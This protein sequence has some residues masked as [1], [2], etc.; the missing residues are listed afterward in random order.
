M[1]GAKVRIGLIGGG[2]MGRGHLNTFKKIEEGEIV[3]VADPSPQSRERVVKDFNLPVFAS[4]AEL[5]EATGP[6]GCVIA[7][8]HPVHLANALDCFK[9]GVHVFTE[10]PMTSKISEADAMIAAARKAKLMLAVMFQMRGN[11]ATRRAKEILDAGTLGEIRRVNMIHVGLRTNAYYR[12]CPWRGR[13]QSEGGGVLVNQSPH[14]LDRVVYLTGMPA[15]VLARTMTFGHPIETEDQAEA[16]LLYPNGATGYLFMSTAEA[17]AMNRLEIS[18]DRG[19][20]VIDDDNNKLLLGKLPGSCRE[21]LATN[22]EE[23]GSLKG[24]WSEVDLTP[25]PGEETGH[26]VCLRD[27]CRAIRDNRA[28]MVTGEDGKRSL[29]LANA[30]TY[31]SFAGAEVKFPLGRKAYDELYAFGVANGEGSSLTKLIPLW[32]KSQA[33]PAKASKASKAAKPARKAARKAGKRK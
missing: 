13:W 6:A 7:S 10:K 3:G 20:L 18:C 27:F 19:R 32:R 25:R 23:W 16:M 26:I 2:G 28:P 31:S 21:F 29:E 11:I 9:R 17:P 22:P 4:A 12:I 24:E 15:T 8:P 1:S 14:T 30:I 33:K 5:I